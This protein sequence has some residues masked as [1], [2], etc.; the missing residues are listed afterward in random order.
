MFE[1]PC[2]FPPHIHYWAKN[3][4]PV[5]ALFDLLAHIDQNHRNEPSGG[6][7]SWEEFKKNCTLPLG[8]DV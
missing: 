7:M 4:D 1:L 6:M 2:P 8:Q 3:N 5:A